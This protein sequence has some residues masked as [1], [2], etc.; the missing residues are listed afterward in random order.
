[1]GLEE[2]R[3][4][5]TE[6]WG[7]LPAAAGLGTRAIL[8][9]AA[10][11]RLAALVL[12]GA[13]PL[14]DFPDRDLAR[15]ALAGTG[16]VVSVDALPSASTRQ[17]DVVLPA[18]MA[19]EKSGTT[20]NLEGR[21]SRVFSKVTPPGTARADWMIAVELAERLGGDLGLESAEQIT[22]EIAALAPAY[23]GVTV[24]RLSES[25]DGVVAG[26][27]APPVE[28]GAEL[29]AVGATSAADA[30]EVHAAGTPG[31]SELVAVEPT[32]LHVPDAPAADPP[33][34]LTFELAVPAPDRYAL[35]LVSHR[36]L[37]DDGV[38]VRHARSLAPL[39]AEGASAMAMNPGDLER[40]GVKDGDQVRVSSRRTT[41]TL[42]ARSSTR[43][44]R[45]GAFL[46]FAQTG[47][48]AADLVDAAAPVTDVR[49][50]TLG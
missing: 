20:T 44:P 47:P 32:E 42:M 12:L 45:G 13:D 5:F 33:P 22:E 18:R 11:G 16:F 9:Q 31:E 48:G 6:A 3:D 29:A 41:L 10:A 49:V 2:G 21:V 19:A 1:V 50:E 7:A 46:A 39:A 43:V 23:R 37:Y 25:L 34:L 36:M 24:E 17:A 4:W 8:E 28:P 14:A 30:P 27:E 26:R 15:R 40:L 38:L 35:R